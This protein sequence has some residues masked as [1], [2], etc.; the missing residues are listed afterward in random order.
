MDS[1]DVAT[2]N[3]FIERALEQSSDS[4]PVLERAGSMLLEAGQR[5]AALAV[6]CLYYTT[7]LISNL[8]RL[9]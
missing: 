1:F 3:L 7:C 9:C 5:D 2:A 6:S 8:L 4:A